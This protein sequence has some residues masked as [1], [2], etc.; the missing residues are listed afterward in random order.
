[1]QLD[2][3]K[4]TA[5]KFEVNDN[6]GQKPKKVS[7]IAGTSNYGK[8]IAVNKDEENDILIRLTQM[9]Y[10]KK[11]NIMILRKESIQQKENLK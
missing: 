3:W 5:L 10:T 4:K 9:Q 2:K 6:D 8:A 11:K 7:I 1:M